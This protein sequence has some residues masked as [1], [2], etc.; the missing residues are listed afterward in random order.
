[1]MVDPEEYSYIDG[2]HAACCV[3]IQTGVNMNE[4]SKYSMAAIKTRV[5]QDGEFVG[6]KAAMSDWMS[7][8]AM[9]WWVS[10]PRG[11]AGYRVPDEAKNALKAH[12]KSHAR[13]RY[14][15]VGALFLYIMIQVVIAV[16]SRTIIDWL[17]N[18]FEEQERVDHHLKRYFQDPPKSA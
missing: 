7:T 3:E 14:G 17:F 9:A 5:R 10:R 11:N 8:H 12:L 4:P 13:Q 1:M 6:K 18:N 16:V 2:A 15:F